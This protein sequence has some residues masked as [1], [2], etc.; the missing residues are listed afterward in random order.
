MH[1]GTFIIRGSRAL[2]PLLLLG[3]MCSLAQ[4]TIIFSVTGGTSTDPTPEPI[5]ESFTTPGGGPWNNITFNFYS[6]VPAT[7]PLA[8]GD[9]FLLTQEYL[10]SPA[11]LSSSTPGFLA[12]SISVSGGIYI[13]ASS[14][15]L[16]PGTEYWLY[17][18]TAIQATG[19]GT[20]GSPAGQA[21]FGGDGSFSAGPGGELLNFTLDGTVVPEPSTWLMGISGLAIL[22]IVKL[23][24]RNTRSPGTS[25]S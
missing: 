10:G 3:G 17:E 9:A 15:V 20:G 21:Y 24:G 8:A 19:S 18:D 7:T 5:G 14:L 2:A 23:R 16:N 12:E 4:G 11:G 22:G 1:I 25:R 6:D 13:F